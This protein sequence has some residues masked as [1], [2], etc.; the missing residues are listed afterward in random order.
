MWQANERQANRV[1]GDICRLLLRLTELTALNLQG[2]E[3]QD[4][5]LNVIRQVFC[6]LPILRAC[7]LARIQRQRCSKS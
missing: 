2:L 6:I 3:I 4:R 1:Q 7:V 5:E